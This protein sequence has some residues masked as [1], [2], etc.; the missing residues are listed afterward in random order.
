LARP[1]GFE[2][3]TLRSVLQSRFRL[4]NFCGPFFDVN[5]L[6]R[7]AEHVEIEVLPPLVEF[8]HIPSV[9]IVFPADLDIAS[10]SG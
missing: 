10:N 4:R 7:K 2:P 8:P 5:G 6:G 3:P 1:A 9:L